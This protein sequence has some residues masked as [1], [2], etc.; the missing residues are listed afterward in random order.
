MNRH[1]PIKISVGDLLRK[2]LGDYNPSIFDENIPSVKKLE[3]LL[4]IGNTTKYLYYLVQKKEREDAYQ[5]LEKILTDPDSSLATERER[6]IREGQGKFKKDLINRYFPPRLGQKPICAVTGTSVG[7]PYL[8]EA[9]HIKP[10]CKDRDNNVANGI[11][12][13]VDIHRLWDAGLIGFEPLLDVE[14]AKSLIVKEYRLRLSK[15]LL[16]QIMDADLPEAETTIVRHYAAL[17]GRKLNFGKTGR[18]PHPDEMLARWDRFKVLQKRYRRNP[19]PNLIDIENGLQI[20]TATACYNLVVSETGHHEYTPYKSVDARCSIT[21]ESSPSYTY[22]FPISALQDADEVGELVMFNV[23][24]RLFMGDEQLV[25]MLDDKH[26]KMAPYQYKAIFGNGLSSASDSYKPGFIGSLGKERKRGLLVLPTGLGK[27]ITAA[28]CYRWLVDNWERFKKDSPNKKPKLLF[29]AHQTALLTAAE[30]TFKDFNPD[31][32]KSLTTAVIHSGPGKHLFGGTLPDLGQVGDELADIQGIFITSTTLAEILTNPDHLPIKKEELFKL[33]DLIIIDEAHHA[34]AK[35]IQISKNGRKSGKRTQKSDEEL[36]RYTK[37][38]AVLEPNIFMLGMT[39]TPS[40]TTYNVFN[41]NVIYSLGVTQSSQSDI[42]TSL[43]LAINKGYLTWIQYHQIQDLQEVITAEDW[44]TYKILNSSDS[45]DERKEVI[46]KMKLPSGEKWGDGP[47]RKQVSNILK[48]ENILSKPTQHDIYDQICFWSGIPA[49]EKTWQKCKDKISTNLAKDDIQK[50]LSA[51]IKE[52][53]GKPSFISYRKT[54]VFCDG[55]S[56]AASL[57]NFL[58]KKGIQAKFWVSEIPEG[59][60]SLGLKDIKDFKKEDKVLCVVAKA[61]EGVDLPKISTIIFYTKTDSRTTLLQRIGRGLRLSSNKRVV[62]I[63]DLLGNYPTLL[64]ALKYGIGPQLEWSQRGARNLYCECANC[65]TQNDRRNKLCKACGSELKVQNDDAPI[66]GSEC[67]FSL[68]TREL[69]GSY[70]GLR[71]PGDVIDLVKLERE[72]NGATT[73]RIVDIIR[74]WSKDYEFEDDNGTTIRFPGFPYAWS[75]DDFD[76]K[77]N[78][79][80]KPMTDEWN[81]VNNLFVETLPPDVSLAQL[82][83]ECS[84]SIE[85]CGFGQ[86]LDGSFFY[87]CDKCNNKIYQDSWDQS[88]RQCPIETCKKV[89]DFWLSCIYPKKIEARITLLTYYVNKLLVSYKGPT[90][91]FKSH[92]PLYRNISGLGQAAYMSDEDFKQQLINNGA[93]ELLGYYGLPQKRGR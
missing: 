61:D 54:M 20:V 48:N 70:V 39:A 55:I 37:I 13:R 31:F 81:Y 2:L 36:Q 23:F 26:F 77:L 52:M 53:K 72:D 7:V 49:N 6:K 69:F 35:T 71:L 19:L 5:E 41:N 40:E 38:L 11:L 50:A 30:S 80:K 51:Y 60:E 79:A 43:Y 27:T 1:N 82:F 91:E 86:D 88:A 21:S 62:H 15:D 76:K 4:D 34:S 66:M 83:K 24:N 18:L 44:N 47:L 22:A 29:I 75:S 74:K 9:A 3:L 16:Q 58:S 10:Y 57:A 56:E 67:S 93:T 42:M 63:I 28:L 68:K 8:V 46:G 25:P 17:E 59:S 92:L 65:E 64:D 90:T 45:S 87:Q 32:T 78:N 84:D 73:D 33:F 89:S 85:N 12:L 14:D